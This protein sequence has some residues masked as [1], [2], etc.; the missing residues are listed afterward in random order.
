MTGKLFVGIVGL[1][2][3]VGAA[4]AEDVKPVY[5]L[6]VNGLGCPFCAYGVERELGSVEGVDKVDIDIKRAVA[7]VTMAEGATLDEDTA[8]QA[9]EEAGFDLRSFGPVSRE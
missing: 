6:G 7:V 4:A 8:K 2:F 5:E 1:M 9:V 3:L